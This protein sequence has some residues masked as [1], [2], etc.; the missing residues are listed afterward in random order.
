MILGDKISSMRKQNGWSQEE[1]AEKLDISRQS[2]SKWESGTSIPDLD[3]IIKLSA[4]FGVSTDYLLK[5]EIQ[6]FTPT[7]ST[8]ECQKEP[9]R[10]LALDQV[11]EYLNVVER[12]SRLMG[13]GVFLCVLA[14]AI[15][16]GIVGFSVQNGSVPLFLSEQT[17]SGVGTAILLVLLAIGVAILISNGIKLSKYAYLERENFTLE[18][19]IYGIVEKKQDQFDPIFRHCIAGGVTLCI[20]G[21]VPLMIAAA[22]DAGDQIYVW[23]TAVLLFFIA[24]G[25]FLFVWSGMIH[26]SYHKILQIGDYSPAKKELE[27]RTS[28]FPGVYWC[29]ATAFYLGISFGFDSWNRSWIVWPVAGVLFAALSQLLKASAQAKIDK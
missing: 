9:S 22:I 17:A 1:L 15:L 3:K 20:I 8:K 28:W 13:I 10:K 19:G 16:I 4:I 12:I 7:E 18:Y 26:S 23:C 5:D 14:P 2:V 11:T 24:C 25:V 27:K 6:E 21:V 29:A